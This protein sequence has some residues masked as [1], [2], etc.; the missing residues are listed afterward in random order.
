MAGLSSAAL[1]P[2][3]PPAP[4]SPHPSCSYPADWLGDLYACETWSA[5]KQYIEGLHASGELR[6][7]VFLALLAQAGS[8]SG[9]L[10]EMAQVSAG[11]VAVKTAQLRAC[12]RG[13][14]VSAWLGMSRRPLKPLRL[15]QASLE[16]RLGELL[17]ADAVDSGTEL[18][19][20][21]VAVLQQ[22]ATDAAAAGA[23][24]MAAQEALQELALPPRWYW[25]AAPSDWDDWQ[26]RCRAYVLRDL[27]RCIH[28]R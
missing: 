9:R 18:W 12:L 22:R 25:K 28:W 17:G 6:R 23:V 10:E 19:L 5:A 27:L 24:V 13:L 2:L 1:P 16:G 7:V 3:V 11:A 14:P 20:A 8:R 15:R 4:T 26:Q 21:T